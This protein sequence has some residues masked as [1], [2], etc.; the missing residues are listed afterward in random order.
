MNGTIIFLFLVFSLYSIQF[1]TQ[2]EGSGGFRY[3]NFDVEAFHRLT[4]HQMTSSV[5]DSMEDCTFACLAH[6]ECFSFNL[7]NPIAKKYDCEL[8]R[9]DKYNSKS[10]YNHSKDF[11]HF[12]I[13]VSSL[14]EAHVVIA[15]SWR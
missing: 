1:T 7:G 4:S 12:F 6:W 8:I 13:R 10:T 15:E 2:S 11:H 5:V 14:F 3:F 9:T